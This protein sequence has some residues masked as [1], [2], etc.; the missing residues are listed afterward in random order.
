MWPFWDIICGTDRGPGVPGKKNT[1]R[2]ILKERARG[3]APAKNGEPISGKKPKKILDDDKEDS[4]NSEESLTPEDAKIVSLIRRHAVPALFDATA[5]PSTI[6]IERKPGPTGG[7]S[8]EMRRYALNPS[9]GSISAP[10]SALGGPGPGPVTV[11]L[12]HFPPARLPA[13]KTLGIAREGVFYSWVTGG[14]ASEKVF[15]MV[16]QIIP[17]I[18]FAK[19]DMATGEKLLIMEDLEAEGIGISAS[20]LFGHKSPVNWGKGAK[21]DRD[22]VKA[23]EAEFGKTGPEIPK[24]SDISEMQKAIEKICSRKISECGAHWHALHWRDPGTAST[25]RAELPDASFLNGIWFRNMM[26]DTPAEEAEIGKQEWQ[27]SLEFSVNSWRKFVSEILP[28]SDVKLDPRLVKFV[29]RAITDTTWENYIRD[30]RSRSWTLIHGDFHPGNMIWRTITG[31]NKLHVVLVD[32]EAVG[33]GNGPQEIAQA[34]ISHATPEMRRAYEREVM[35]AY[36]DVIVKEAPRFDNFFSFF[37]FLS[38]K[39]SNPL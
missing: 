9:G 26:T 7:F 35:D 10:K 29:D 14:K 24:F 34:L 27:G 4:R 5:D 23:Y 17:R 28:T 8:G 39:C 15:R 6:V 37:N 30:M 13:A 31:T 20:N 19:G 1:T 11:V 33:F 16:S 32:W 21:V 12:K 3:D 38:F 36:F 25:S 18:F 2:D 22:I